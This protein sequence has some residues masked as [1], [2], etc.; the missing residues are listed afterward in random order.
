MNKKRLFFLLICFLCISNCYSKNIKGK[1]N[2]DI[3][4]IIEI[5]KCSLLS[6]EKDNKIFPKYIL[7][8][9][10]KKTCCVKELGLTTNY[11]FGQNLRLISSIELKFDSN[12]IELQELNRIGKCKIEIVLEPVEKEL[13]KLKDSY[14]EL[15]EE[16]VS[17]S[18][19]YLSYKNK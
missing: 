9:R 16:I 15:N 18:F 7:Y 10:L 1:G 4:K 17:N 6:E 3:G 11:S 14:F 5:E 19:F 8:L 2:P 12:S 13:T